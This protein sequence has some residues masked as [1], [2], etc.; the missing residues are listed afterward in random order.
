[1]RHIEK[2][3]QLLGIV[4][5]EQVRDRSNYEYL[6][7]NRI[8]FAKLLMKNRKK[9]DKF[10]LPHGMPSDDWSSSRPPTG[11]D[12]PPTLDGHAATSR[13]EPPNPAHVPSRA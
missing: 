4:E 2:V 3:S 5:P 8:V 12:Q 7:G 13:P 9:P 10:L 1:M 6:E 11:E